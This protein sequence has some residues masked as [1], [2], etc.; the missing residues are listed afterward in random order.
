MVYRVSMRLVSLAFVFLVA[1]SAAKPSIA[2]VTLGAR[3]SADD[4]RL[5]PGDD[6]DT[7]LLR[8]PGSYEGR[9]LDEVRI[10]VEDGVVTRVQLSVSAG[11]DAVEETRAWFRRICDRIGGK[12]DDFTPSPLGTPEPGEEWDPVITTT[13]RCE[14]ERDGLAIEAASVENSASD[15][16]NVRVS[17]EATRPTAER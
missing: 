4:P 13:S 17:I 15:F 10:E 1:C 16:R 14:G 2:G 11:E 8:D 9:S 7:F 5:T 3:A 6:E 12:V